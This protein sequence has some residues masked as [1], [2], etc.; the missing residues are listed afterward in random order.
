MAKAKAIPSADYAD[1]TQ[2]QKRTP[3][4][5]EPVETQYSMVFNKEDSLEEKEKKL[6]QACKLRNHAEFYIMQAIG[7]IFLEGEWL[8]TYKVNDKGE[9]ISVP[10]GF[11]SDTEY[12]NHLSD[13]TEYSRVQLIQLIS[14]YRIY[15]KHEEFLNSIGF[16]NVAS[17]RKIHLLEK[18]MVRV[19]AGQMTKTELKKLLIEGSGNALK[20]IILSEQA[21]IPGSIGLDADTKISVKGDTLFIDNLPALKI[22]SENAA[23]LKEALLAYFKAEKKKAELG[24]AFRENVDFYSKK[25]TT[26]VSQE[27]IPVV[28]PVDSDVSDPKAFEKAAAKEMDRF[29]KKWKLEH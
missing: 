11:N 22:V 9:R 1:P 18:A 10:G 19:N 23:P 16:Q 2:V 27:K 6:S 26:L 21:K 12:L 25:L 7:Y 8:I 3:K 17:V 14:A 15:L 4:K 5:I 29:Y 13:I 20:A 28:I 24:E